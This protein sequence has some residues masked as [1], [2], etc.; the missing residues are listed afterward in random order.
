VDDAID[1]G[2]VGFLRTQIEA[3]FFAHH[4]S[5]EAADR[6]LLPMGRAHD[7]NNGWSLRSAEHREHASLLRARPAFALVGFFGLS[8]AKLMLLAGG[9]LGRNG[10]PLAGG[11]GFG[12]GD[13]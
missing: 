10:N 2:T 4:A 6:V 3:E 5:E 9:L 8:L 11:K 13:L 1:L 12:C 7:G